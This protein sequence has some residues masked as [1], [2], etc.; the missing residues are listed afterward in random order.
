MLVLAPAACCLA[1]V[2]FHEALMA[3][4]RGVHAHRAAAPAKPQEL[5]AKPSKKAGRGAVKVRHD[6]HQCA[7]P[8]AAFLEGCGILPRKGRYSR[9]MAA[10]KDMRPEH[11]Q[12]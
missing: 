12:T 9:S 6:E 8:E 2:A 7:L 10:N 11:C 5:P 3:L 4:F 1:G